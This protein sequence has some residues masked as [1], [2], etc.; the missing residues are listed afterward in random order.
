MRPLLAPEILRVWEEGER[1]L[2]LDRALT[3]LSA[4]CPEQ[5]REELALMSIA[6]RDAAIWQLRELTFGPQFNGFTECPQCGERL[7]FNLDAS[8]FRNNQ[9]EALAD[10][11]YEFETGGVKLQYRLPNSRDLAM[12]ATCDDVETARDLLVRRCV[13]RTGEETGAG[14]DGDLTTEQIAQLVGRMAESAP[15]AEVL[16]DFNCPACGHVWQSLFDIVMFFWTE[17]AAEA[18]RLLREVHALA[19][20]YG[21]RE[22][23][24][25][26]LSPRRRQAYLEM[27]S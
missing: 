14:L 26:A 17:L 25:L 27:I 11:R 6:A 1:Q 24:I 3:M 15:Q 10:D 16:L 21:W 2:P 13:A 20:A 7:E 12:V 23:E 9:S 22:A 18:R 4:G 5:T 8:D 19:R